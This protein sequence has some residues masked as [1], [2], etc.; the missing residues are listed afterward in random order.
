MEECMGKT[1]FASIL[2]VAVL[3]PETTANQVEQLCSDAKRYGYACVAVMPHRVKQT[4]ELLKGTN[5]KLS[6]AVGFPFGT[7]TAAVK[8]FETAEAIDNGANEVD[9][10]MN[11]GRMKDGDFTAVKEDM[12]AVVK[13]AKGKNKDIIVKVILETCLL[14]DSEIEKACKIAEEAGMDFVKCST[15]FNSA[16][17][18]SHVLSLM[19]KSVSDR[20]QVKASGQVRTYEKAVE[21]TNCG[22]TRL[23]CSMKSG[24]AITTA[25]L[26]G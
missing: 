7:T 2:D 3:E 25:A 17:A 1:N 10:V 19:K 14:T 5:I 15:G 9:F 11:V 12:A 24:I 23:G 18:N 6:V 20:V 13:A 22:C 16:G 8:A 26:N 4:A 21:F